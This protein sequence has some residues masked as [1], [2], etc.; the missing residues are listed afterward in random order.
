MRISRSI[1]VLFLVSLST[2]AAVGAETI[3]YFLGHAVEVPAPIMLVVFGLA[4]SAVGVGL[5]T[6]SLYPRSARHLTST[7]RHVDRLTAA[8][9]QEAAHATL[10]SVA[11]S[12][13]HR[14]SPV[15]LVSPRRARARPRPLRDLYSHLQGFTWFSCDIQRC[16]SNFGIAPTHSRTLARDAEVGGSFSM[17]DF[18]FSELK[19][20]ISILLLLYVAILIALGAL[21]VATRTDFVIAKKADVQTTTSP[22]AKIDGPAAQPQ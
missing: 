16:N 7:R 22:D 12:R 8:S 21:G 14:A 1:L 4:L 19:L 17:S 5:Q 10:S 2:P 11:L 18:E 20:E 15:V 9:R 3:V 6:A 13:L